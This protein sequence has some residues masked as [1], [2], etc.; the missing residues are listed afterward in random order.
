[1]ASPTVCPEK[2]ANWAPDSWAPD[3]GAPKIFSNKVIFLQ[4][5][6]YISYYK[7]KFWPCH[8][9][10]GHRVYIREY[11]FGT[12]LSLWN[13]LHSN[14]NEF[15]VSYWAQLSRGPTVRNP[16]VRPKKVAY[17]AADSWA[18][19]LGPGCPGP[20]LKFSFGSRMQRGILC[21]IL[22]VARTRDGFC[23]HLMG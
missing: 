2:V 19:G 13:A 10:L 11:Y 8:W 22:N 18:P 7:M 17:W 1:M 16:T 21:K 5:L 6:W 4:F 20:Y 14:L 3:N 15:V 9:Y 23:V 12:F